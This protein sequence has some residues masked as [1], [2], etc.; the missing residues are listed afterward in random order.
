MESVSGRR[1]QA[2]Q[3]AVYFVEMHADDAV[4]AKFVEASGCAPVN[5]R[6]VGT[7]VCRKLQRLYG[8]TAETE[9]FPRNLAETFDR[10]TQGLQ[11]EIRSQRVSTD[12]GGQ[13]VDWSVWLEVYRKCLDDMRQTFGLPGDA[14]QNRAVLRTDPRGTAR[15]R[16]S[17]D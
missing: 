13:T 3:E 6:D 1:M 5:D 17:T 12:V 4:K 15:R 7:Q 8:R 9:S 10:H 11:P 14:F 2:F 16:T